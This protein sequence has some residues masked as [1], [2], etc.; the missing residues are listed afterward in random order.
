MEGLS[1][2]GSTPARSIW[3]AV[4]AQRFFLCFMIEELG[5]PYSEN[6]EREW[7]L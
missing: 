3:N 1:D 5:K 7:S 4:F 6:Q 2:A